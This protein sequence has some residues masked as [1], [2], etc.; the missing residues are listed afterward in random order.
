MLISLRLKIQSLSL[1]WSSCESWSEVSH[2][3]KNDSMYFKGFGIESLCLLGLYLINDYRL[4][5]VFLLVGVGFSGMAISGKL[6]SFLHPL[7]QIKDCSI[8]LLILLPLFH[9]VLVGYQVNPLDLAPQYAHI[10]TGFTRTSC[11]GSVLSTVLAGAIRQ[12]VSA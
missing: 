8:Y 2:C 9:F 3:L 6:V 10:V 7:I 11:I 5:T 12:K 1:S 4:A